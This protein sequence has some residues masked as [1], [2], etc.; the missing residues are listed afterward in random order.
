MLERNSANGNSRCF[1]V[2]VVLK[3]M[4]ARV[5]RTTAGGLTRWSI[6]DLF[7]RH[8]PA[9]ELDRALQVLIAL[10]RIRAVTEQTSGRPLTRYF[11]V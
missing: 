6:M 2:L 4:P 5:L 3:V 8:K 10:S 7:G 1:P 9:A 11:V